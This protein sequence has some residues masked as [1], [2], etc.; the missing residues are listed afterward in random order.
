MGQ[1]ITRQIERLRTPVIMA[2]NGFALGGGC[3]IA[4]A[5]DIRIASEN[6]KFGQPEVNLGDHARLRRI[7]TDDA[8]RWEGHGD[9]SVP[10]RRDDR[11][12]RSAARRLGGEGRAARGAAR[13]K[14]SASATPLPRRRRLQSPRPSARSTTARIFP[15]TMRSN[16]KRSSSARSSTRRTL[17]KARARSSK[18]ANR[19]GKASDCGPHCARCFLRSQCGRSP[20]A[21]MTTGRAR[22]RC[23]STRSSDP[24]F[25]AGR[26]AHT[27][28][29]NPRNSSC[30]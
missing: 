10:D 15:S 25:D 5:G 21:Q 16:S 23:D 29:Q 18:S 11:R 14:P 30:C 7:T 12:P 28:L 9:V 1:S 20:R 26:P 27:D 24:A 22:Y 8:A 17:R 2:I 4:M 19:F 6:A 13:T 3:E